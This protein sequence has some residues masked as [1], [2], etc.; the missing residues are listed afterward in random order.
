M[1]LRQR[2]AHRTASHNVIY[3]SLVY[4]NIYDIQYFYYII[5]RSVPFSVRYT[6]E[7]ILQFN[8]ILVFNNISIA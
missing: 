4:S 6:A 8:I 1:L 2:K 7:G 5:Y 3:L